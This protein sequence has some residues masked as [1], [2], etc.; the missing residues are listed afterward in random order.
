[1]NL[2]NFKTAHKILAV[3]A[4]LS[5]VAAGITAGGVFSP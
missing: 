4:L 2:G 5:L 1:M 3:I